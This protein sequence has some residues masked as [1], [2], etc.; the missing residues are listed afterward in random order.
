MCTCYLKLLLFQMKCSIVYGMLGA[1][2]FSKARKK[3]KRQENE[4]KKGGVVLLLEDF[5]N[6]LCGPVLP[7][8]LFFLL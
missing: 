5:A 8:I 3:K 6:M 2:N 4:K 1:C 7:A